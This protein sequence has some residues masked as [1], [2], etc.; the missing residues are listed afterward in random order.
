MG[1]PS[2]PEVARARL[3]KVNHRR[4]TLASEVGAE[5][6]ASLLNR[7]GGAGRA[8]RFGWLETGAKV[9]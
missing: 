3:A 7:L 8:S 4:A 6:L 9:G 1:P 2:W 5:A